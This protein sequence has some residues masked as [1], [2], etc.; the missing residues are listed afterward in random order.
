[1]IQ[2][3]WLERPTDRTIQNDWGHS[4]TVRERVLQYRQ[5]LDRIV[6]SGAPGDTRNVQN[7]EIFWTEWR[8]VPVVDELE[9]K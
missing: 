2:L 8:D 1:M 6:Y 7:R 5:E 9:Q 3:R 4:Q